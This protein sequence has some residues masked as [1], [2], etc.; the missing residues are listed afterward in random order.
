MVY[1]KTRNDNFQVNSGNKYLKLRK[2]YVEKFRETTG[3]EIQGRHW[4]GNRQ[5]SMEGIDVEDFPNSIDPDRNNIKSE[6]HS[7]ISDDNE[8]DSCN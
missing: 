3:I 1:K 5:L 2:D 4:D 6:F 7:Y 8:Q